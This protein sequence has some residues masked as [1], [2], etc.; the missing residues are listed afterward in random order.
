MR[1]TNLVERAVTA[2]K[3]AEYEHKKRKEAERKW[4]KALLKIKK[5]ENIIRKF[6]NENTSSSALPVYLKSAIKSPN[7]LP[8]GINPRGKPKGGNGSTRKI[9]EKVDKKVRVEF[10]KEYLRK[11]KEKHGERLEIRQVKLYVWE[12]PEIK[13]YTTEF[14]VDRAYLGKKL[15]AQAVNPKLPKRGQIGNNLVAFIEEAKIAFAGSYDKVSVFTD[16]LFGVSFSQQAMNDCIE[17][18]GEEFEPEYN[19]LKEELRKSDSAGIDETS[20]PV[21]GKNWFLW[22][23]VTTNIIFFS[24]ENSRGKKILAKILGTLFNGGVIS[25]CYSIYRGFAKWFQK[26]WAHLLRSTYNLYLKNKRKDIAKL[27]RWLSNLFEKMKKFLEEN[28]PSDERGKKYK[29]Y[30]KELQ[31]IINYPWKS[32]EAKRI[33]KNRLKAFEG[34]WLTAIKVPGVKLTNNDAERPIRSAIPTRKL[35]GG[36]RTERGAKN[37]AILMSLRMTWK[38]RGLSPY[39]TLIQKLREINVNMTL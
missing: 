21:N 8:V 37:Y 28:P 16:N 29:L 9:P 7:R 17:R 19:E 2:E 35:L 32:E 20:W 25:D 30:G 26:C 31:R 22:I 39:H 15:I 38:L 33:V 18:T 24:I 1:K 4:K 14:T 13:A 36:H 27:H 11:L 3:R 23:F 12:I 34:H 6:H 10:T 5:L